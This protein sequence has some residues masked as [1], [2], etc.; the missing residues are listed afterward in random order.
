M[1]VWHWVAGARRSVVVACVFG[2][3]SLVANGAAV[4]GAVELVFG[5]PEAPRAMLVTGSDAAEIPVPAKTP[6]GSLWKLFVYAYLD[7]VGHRAPEYRCTGGDVNEEAYCCAPGERIGADE[8]LVK[9]C[10]LFFAPRRLGIDPAEWRRYWLA[11]APQSPWV[12]DLGALQ[13]GTEVAVNSLL[14]ALVAIDGTTRQRTMRTLQRLGFET[15]GRPLLAHLG[16]AL[17][18]KTWSWHDAQGRRIGGFAGWLADGTPLWLRGEGTSGQIIERVSPWLAAQLPAMAPN[19]D[20][21]VRVRFFARYPL[22][23]V[24]VNEQ[25]A[26]AGPLTGRA[27]VSFTNGQQLIFAGSGDMSLSMAGGQPQIEGRFGLNDYLARVIQREGAA[28]PASAAR[29]LAVAARTYL[30]R[31]AG[32]SG[33]CYEISDDSRAQRVSAAPAG[34]AARASAEWSDGLVLSGVA[35]RYHLDR[36]GPNRLVWKQAVAW[37]AN[38][39]RWDEILARAYGNAGLALIGDTDAGECRPLV[40]AQ[41]WLAA[42]QAKWKRQLAGVE[43]FEPPLQAPRICRL[44]HGNPYADVERGRLYAVGVGTANDRL[45]ITHEYLHFAFANHPRGRDEDFVEH[46]ARRLVGMP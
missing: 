8:A 14:A 19:E 22:A 6:L 41:A 37:A 28:Q 9:S 21:C 33:G 23:A 27:R 26:V 3:F 42:R 2:T 46:T 13:P 30:A 15:R 11:R 24:H 25:P 29:A 34:S 7:D 35:G 38:G 18:V 45:T 32:Y 5:S 16:S 36:A 12:A 44:D 10:S 39:A 43:G 4:R 17:R 40:T 20:A 1:S 31:H